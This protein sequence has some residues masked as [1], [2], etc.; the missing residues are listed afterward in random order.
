MTL[1]PN[2]VAKLVFRSYNDSE[3]EI[4]INPLCLMIYQYQ[5]SPEPAS[6]GS[7][8]VVSKGDFDSFS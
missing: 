2:I 1:P 5:H 7:S 4:K 8:H 6:F 3:A